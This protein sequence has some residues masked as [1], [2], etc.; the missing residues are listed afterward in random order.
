MLSSGH[1]LLIY[2]NLQ[3]SFLKKES[4]LKK[5]GLLFRF[6]IKKNKVVEKMKRIIKTCLILFSTLTMAGC[7]SSNAT[8]NRSISNEN[9]QEETLKEASNHVISHRGASGEEIEHTIEAYNLALDYGSK[10]IEQDLVSSKQGTLYISH[11][12][13]AQRITGVDKN[14]S[15]MSD[16]EINKLSTS[17]GQK[18]L[19]LENVFKKY[20][21]RA[22]FV[23]ELKQNNL[24]VN[25]FARL[26]K[27]Y[28]VQNKIIVQASDMKTIDNLQKKIP[29]MPKL[30]LVKDQQMLDGALKDKNI[31]IIGANVSLMNLKNVKKVHL[32]NKKFSVWTLNN[33]KEIKKAINLD[34]DSYFTN[35]TAK[36]LLL[37][38]KYR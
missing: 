34:V 5:F 31:D 17:D 19:T 25:E 28:K 21:K 1:V 23:V 7:A 12:E 24:Q 30:M 32:K 22:N 18:I 10:Y 38:N 6:A 20:K 36:A 2:H 11:D 4:K 8:Q 3:L 26:V 29:D 14:F 13:S 35:F 9:K 15:D 33:T 27:K 37:E 16:N